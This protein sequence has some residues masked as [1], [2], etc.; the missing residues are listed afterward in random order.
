[1]TVPLGD[2]Y[3]RIDAMITEVLPDYRN[4]PDRMA[5]NAGA[6]WSSIKLAGMPKD[7]GQKNKVAKYTLSWEIMLIHG[8]SSLGNK[9]V[10]RA[11]MYDDIAAI[12]NYFDT[13]GDLLLDTQSNPDDYINGFRPSTLEFTFIDEGDFGMVGQSGTNMRATRYSLQF[14]HDDIL[15]GQQL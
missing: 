5:G 1:M 14:R 11:W 13:H 8:A 7:A 3:T 2:Y 10:M 9:G 12:Q 15:T 4:T 6:K